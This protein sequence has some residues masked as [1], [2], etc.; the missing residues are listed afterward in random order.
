MDLFISINTV[1]I[2]NYSQPSSLTKSANFDRHNLGVDE[3]IEDIQ[4]L[5]EEEIEVVSG[6]GCE[7]EVRCNTDGVCEIVIRCPF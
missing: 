4:V 1:K 6:G 7:A 2:F 3:M 5:S